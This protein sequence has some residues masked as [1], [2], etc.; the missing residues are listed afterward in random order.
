VPAPRVLARTGL[1]WVIRMAHRIKPWLA[2]AI[3]SIAVFGSADRTNKDHC[4]VAWE[5][6]GEQWQGYLTDSAATPYLAM[7]L[8]THHG[9]PVDYR[10]SRQDFVDACR[11]G[12]IWQIAPAK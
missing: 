11:V 4:A 9:A 6:A 1:S 5:S 7:M 10:V 8:A 2:A 12:A 3:V